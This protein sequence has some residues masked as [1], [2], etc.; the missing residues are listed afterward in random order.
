M[1]AA[2]WRLVAVMAPLVAAVVALLT[3]SQSWVVVVL[4]DGRTVVASGDVAAPALPPFALAA[5]ALV[6][7]LALSG[8]FFRIVLG[9][10]Q[11]LLGLGVSVSGIIVLP[12][13][14]ASAVPVITEV[15]GLAG[16]ESVR[17]IVASVETTVWP[18]LAIIAGVLGVLAGLVVI[19]SARRWPPRTSRYDA[20]RLAPPA[21]APDDQSPVDSTTAWDSLSDGDDPTNR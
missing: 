7:A 17:A 1:T 18:V 16:V 3:W 19:V 11:S 2:R 9:A 10:L 6:G 12:D 21:T 5:L 4:T 15:S 14:V 8:V 13:P 20:V